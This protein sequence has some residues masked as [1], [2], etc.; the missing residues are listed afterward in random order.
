MSHPDIFRQ[1]PYW[2]SRTWRSADIL[3]VAI[4]RSN[5]T[6]GTAPLLELS[7]SAASSSS[8]IEPVMIR[9]AV[10]LLALTLAYSAMAQN[11][12][13]DHYTCARQASRQ[14]NDDVET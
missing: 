11:H 5:L 2:L 8:P 10:L 4:V 14:K 3:S 1:R 12:A 6:H 7:C 13:A 9:N